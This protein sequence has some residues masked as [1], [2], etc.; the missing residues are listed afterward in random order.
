MDTDGPKV[1]NECKDAFMHSAPAP[2]DNMLIRACT[3]HDKRAKELCQHK[4]ECVL[5]EAHRVEFQLTSPPERSLI[6]ANLEHWQAEAAKFADTGFT[7][8]YWSDAYDR[9]LVEL[10]I[11]AARKGA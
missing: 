6:D 9:R 4:N 11:D 1:T 3:C 7:F 2:K 10:A 8:G 5:V